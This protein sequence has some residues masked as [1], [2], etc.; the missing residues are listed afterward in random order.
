MKHVILILTLLFSGIA[1]GQEITS[2]QQYEALINKAD[3]E[4]KEAQKLRDAKVRKATALYIKALEKKKKEVMVKGDLKA[5]NKIQSQIDNL[6]P[7][8]TATKI[9]RAKVDPNNIDVDIQ[10]T[11]EREKALGYK[12]KRH[13]IGAKLGPDGHY[14]KFVEGFSTWMDAAKDAREKG[15]YLAVITSSEEYVFI[16]KI[17]KI[18]NRPAGG[19]V[20][21][22]GTMYNSNI[23]WVTKEPHN[24][25]LRH[26]QVHNRYT[27]CVIG[28]LEEGICSAYSTGKNGSGKVIT[29]G[30]VIEWDN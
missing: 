1:F 16:A 2:T 27:H 26:K 29:K 11:I 18:D 8:I 25:G 9:E 13:P 20:W 19:N 17:A 14:Y 21:L 22:G 30:Y 6:K 7:L 24:K 23:R 4:L 15:G 10:S 28:S 12:L 3:T 5:A